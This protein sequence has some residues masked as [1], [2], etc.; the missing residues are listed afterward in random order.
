M[1]TTILLWRLYNKIIFDYNSSSFHFTDDESGINSFENQF[2]IKMFG[3][4]KD[5]KIC[6]YTT[7]NTLFEMLKNIE[8]DINNLLYEYREEELDK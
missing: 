5:T 8:A 6:R 2:F 7:L 1:K 4:F 3:E